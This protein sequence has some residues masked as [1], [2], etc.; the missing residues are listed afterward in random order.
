MALNDDLAKQWK[1]FTVA[2]NPT[3]L[4]PADH[5]RLV[6]FVA[7]CHVAGVVPDAEELRADMTTANFSQ[8]VA[9]QVIMLATEDGPA[10]LTAFEK[11]RS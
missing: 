10:L 4:H 1:A 11:L 5:D 8:Q 3:G 2:A 6:T 9:D 7:S